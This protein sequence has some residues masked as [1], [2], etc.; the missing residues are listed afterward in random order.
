MFSSM[1]WL[2]GSLSTFLAVVPADDGQQTFNVLMLLLSPA[3]P[4]RFRAPRLCGDRVL[5]G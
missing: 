3:N 5:S 1:L 4:A 2:A